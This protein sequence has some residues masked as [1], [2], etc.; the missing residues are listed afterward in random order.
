MEDERI[1][2]SSS[3]AI[4]PEAVAGKGFTT[5]LRGYQ[6]AE[7]RQFL[8]RVAE[9]MGAAAT[10]EA[11]LRR[12]L[13][14][15]QSRAAHPELDEAV[16]TASLGEHAGRL[17]AS[18][19]ETAAAITAEAERT[20][21]AILRDAEYRIARMRQEADN[22]MARRVDEADGVSTSLRQSAEADARGIRDQAQSEAEAVVQA[23]RSHGKEMVAEARAVRERMLGDLARRRRVAEVQLE[24]LRVAR[25]RLVEAYDVVRRTLEEVTAELSAAEPEARSLAEAVGRRMAEG[26][27]QPSPRSADPPGRVAYAGNPAPS[28]PA[29]ARR[30]EAPPRPSDLPGRPAMAAFAPAPPPPPPGQSIEGES[31]E[32]QW[33][34]GQPGEDPSG[35]APGSFQPTH[36][37]PPP[38]PAPAAPVAPTST[39]RIGSGNPPVPPA[40]IERAGVSDGHA[41]TGPPTPIPPSVAGDLLVPS[42]GV[43]GGSGPPPEPE[44]QDSGTWTGAGF[45]PSRDTGSGS[46]PRSPEQSSPGPTPAPGAMPSAGSRSSGGSSWL[47]STSG[48]APAPV[49]PGSSRPSTDGGAAP[50]PALSSS[51]PAPAA[52]A[53]SPAPA[54]APAAPAAAVAAPARPP[55]RPQTVADSLPFRSRAVPPTN[56]PSGS[57]ATRTSAGTPFS[58][59]GSRPVPPDIPREVPATPADQP[60]DLSTAE[61]PA[62]GDQSDG[63]A[64]VEELF[65][66]L[67]DHVPAPEP[68][69]RPSAPATAPDLHAGDL[70]DEAALARRDDQLDQLDADLTRGLKRILQDEQN[71][72]LERL[73]QKG[74]AGAST[75]LGDLDHQTSGFTAVA[76]RALSAAYQAGGGDGDDTTAFTLGGRLANDLAAPLRERLERVVA[77]AGDDPDDLAEAVRAAYRHTK[78]QEIEQLVRHH[79]AAAHALGAFASTPGGALLRWVA[80]D[81]GPCPD[82][83]DNTLAGPTPKGAAYPTGQTHPPAHLGCRCLLVPVAT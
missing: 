26:D 36:P 43:G 8:N 4:A 61:V 62:V 76:A 78:V 12:V 65:A 74:R 59:V 22:L 45:G 52:T 33:G 60:A 25:E 56:S 51:A 66:R 27:Q 16:L 80:D 18:A 49:L 83:H 77:A 40:W 14:D 37:A 48:L 54:P 9:E 69:A 68:E 34:G 32:S 17:I 47:A 24:Q 42:A 72:V 79:T 53:P 21:A 39:E 81:E 41:S 57:T 58:G 82:C 5:A 11:E 2:I 19:R 70:V 44:I 10:R 71:D 67:R 28:P 55:L 1:V 13:H 46:R 73:R 64:P 30:P 63:A 38:M 75:V 29:P 31:G 7:V 50:A 15:T 3:A 20:A 35:P 6:P 23:A